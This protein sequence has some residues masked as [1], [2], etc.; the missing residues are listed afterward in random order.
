M[1]QDL[2]ATLIRSDYRIKKVFIRQNLWT[3]S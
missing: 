1:K 3:E 2:G